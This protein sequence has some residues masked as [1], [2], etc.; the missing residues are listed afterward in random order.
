MLAV[1]PDGKTVILSGADPNTVP[2]AGSS[3]PPPATQVIVF[4]TA[5]NTGTTLPIAGATAADF[6]PDS[7]KAFIAAGSSLY[8]YSTLDS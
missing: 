6:S 1:S 7:L 4:N 2:V 3:A 5:S 8:V